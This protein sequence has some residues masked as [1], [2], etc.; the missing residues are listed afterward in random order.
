MTE[1]NFVMQH[2]LMEKLAPSMNKAKHMI[3]QAIEE[4]RLIIL[5]HHNDCDGYC[6]ALALEEVIMPM[7]LAEDDRRPWS[8]FKRL[9]MTTPYYDYGDALKDLMSLKDS[10]KFKRK[11]PLLILLDNGCGEEDVLALKR[12]RQYDVDVLIIDHHI[13]YEKIDDYCDVHV[14]PRAVGGEGDITAGMLGFELANQLGKSNIL[15]AAFAGVADKSEDEFVNQY[16][17]QVPQTKE[18]LEKM[19]WCFDFEAKELR[20]MD[21]DCVKDFFNE[22]QEA[23]VNIIWPELEEKI[24]TYK[25][26][27][28]KAIE[29]EDLGK[30]T[31]LKLKLDEVSL[32]G[33]FPSRGKVIGIA[34]RL[35]EGPRVTIGY[36]SDFVS[37]RV[38]DVP[39]KI[40]EIK[41]LLKEKLPCGAVSGGGHDYAGTL[42]FLPIVKNE[43]VEIVIDYIKQL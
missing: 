17:K 6:G 32:R 13:A 9:P 29:K 39:F 43:V 36:G 20:F 2:P 22:K 30:K 8:R 25:R 40:T 27:V 18:F 3:K 10:L 15:Y 16:L 26:A 11:A 23:T 19:S 7:V 31:L 38:E 1:T 33:D 35:F 37:F 34:H 4:S 5:R 28:Q 24:A 21:N 12:I 42:R 41:S 14:N